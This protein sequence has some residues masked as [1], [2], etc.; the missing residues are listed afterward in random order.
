MHP[1]KN[2]D[3]ICSKEEQ[4]VWSANEL[5][6]NQSEME[7]TSSSIYSIWK[8]FLVLEFLD[9]QQND[10]CQDKHGQHSQTDKKL[11]VPSEKSHV[12][13]RKRPAHVLSTEAVLWLNHQAALCPSERWSGQ[14]T[15]SSRVQQSKKQRKIICR[16]PR[17]FVVKSDRRHI[18]MS[19]TLQITRTRSKIS[20]QTTSTDSE[21]TAEVTV[22]VEESEKSS[23]SLDQVEAWPN[24]KY[25]QW[26]A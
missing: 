19:S 14:I 15:N 21:V 10:F 8:T 2:Q 11:L 9:H 4:V 25:L 26:A 6:K 23:M 12:T 16:K 7:Q 20:S 24:P 1:D 13:L 22:P 18:L 3:K 17:L 5:M